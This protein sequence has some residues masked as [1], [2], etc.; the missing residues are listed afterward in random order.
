MAEGPRGGDRGLAESRADQTRPVGRG[1]L[2]APPLHRASQR[3]GGVAA[4]LMHRPKAS[5]KEKRTG[6]L[7]LCALEVV[8]GVSL[9]CTSATRHPAMLR[10]CVILVCTR[11][12]GRPT[13]CAPC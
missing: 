13:Q 6:S 2:K 1:D 10:S 4:D 11:L 7:R 5:A 12:S 3:H 8:S 9:F